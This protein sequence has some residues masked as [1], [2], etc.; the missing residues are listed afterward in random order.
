M[1]AK[2]TA[3]TWIALFASL[4]L[5]VPVTCAHAALTVT[6]TGAWQLGLSRQT[7]AGRPGSELTAVFESHPGSASLTVAGAVSSDQGWQVEVSRRDMRWHPDLSLQVRRVGNGVGGGVLRGGQSYQPA[8]TV[9]SGLLIG[10]GNRLQVPLQFRLGGF[11]VRV[12][13]ADY[14]TELIYTVVELQ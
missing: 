1:T 8:E 3:A 5:V 6:V 13:P 9:P 12:P 14:A 2:L 4:S 10:C 11:S 7:L